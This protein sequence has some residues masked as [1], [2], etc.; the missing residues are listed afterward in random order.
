MFN[1]APVGITTSHKPA[2][3]E[4]ETQEYRLWHLA[5]GRES[6]PM[7]CSEGNL[8]YSDPRGGLAE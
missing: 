5:K 4:A 3:S 1:V 7:I 8:S 2:T 6:S